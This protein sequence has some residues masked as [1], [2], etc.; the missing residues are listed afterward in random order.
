M[1][2]D[3]VKVFKAL[4]DENRLRI[5]ESLRTSEKC[6]CTLLE[7]LDIVQ[8][9]LSHHMRILVQSHIISSR[10]DGKWTYYSLNEELCLEIKEMTGNLLERSAVYLTAEVCC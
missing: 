9:T 10:R 4:A 2:I 7:E 1:V 8:S 5:I 3:R 6:A